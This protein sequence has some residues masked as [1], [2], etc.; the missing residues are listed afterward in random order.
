MGKIPHAIHGV[1]AIEV[2]RRVDAVWNQDRDDDPG[3]LVSRLRVE[4]LRQPVN[5]HLLKWQHREELARRHNAS[6][7]GVA[8]HPTTLTPVETKA[9]SK[10]PLK[11]VI[12]TK[13]NS[14]K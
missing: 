4:Q 2:Q 6:A 8:T 14:L 5:E 10:S 7:T 9:L 13:L 1:N 3:F 12:A 11:G